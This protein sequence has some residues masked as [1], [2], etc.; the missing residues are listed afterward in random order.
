[1]EPTVTMSEK[2]GEIVAAL[3]KAQGMFKPIIKNRTGHVTY[4]AKDNRPAGSY[5]FEYA[6]LD[7]V[8]DAITDGLSAN[9][10]AHTA[11]V[12]N[13]KITVIL[14]HPSEQWIKSE[15]PVP[16]PLD[17][18]WQEFGKSIT[19]PRRILLCPLVG[20]TAEF[21]DDANGAD[22]NQLQPGPD[23]LQPLWDAIDQTPMKDMPPAEVR[24]WC[25]MVLGRAIPQPSA[26]SAKDLP[27]LLAALAKDTSKPSPESQQ[28]SKPASDEEK[29]ALAKEL[30]NALN[31]LAP[32]GSATDGK[33]AKD[34]SAIKQTAKLTW[35]N[36]MLKLKKPVHGFGE[37]T[38]TELKDLIAKANNG[39][40]PDGEPLPE[41]MNEAEVAK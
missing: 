10:I 13:G 33:T 37:L 2:F 7:A 38:V 21:D 5:D 34:A 19:Y 41:W 24:T 22:G 8:I 6:D 17:K 40:V 3:A 1:M 18:G 16:S 11:M 36:G 9:S 31:T 4:P 35:A 20:V 29:A 26:L 28:A 27:A 25:E 30:N 14:L 15:A 32:W 23:P 39:E 12:A